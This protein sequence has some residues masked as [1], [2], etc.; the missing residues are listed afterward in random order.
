MRYLD[1]DLQLAA[2]SD[3]SVVPNFINITRTRN[4]PQCI[5]SDGFYTGTDTS[6]AAGLDCAARPGTERSGGAAL[7]AGLALT[8]TI[9]RHRRRAAR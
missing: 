2:A 3:D 7:V 4:S 1:R 9:A 8:I 6:A 5:D